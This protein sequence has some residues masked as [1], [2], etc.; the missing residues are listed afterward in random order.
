M[1]G[2]LLK[3]S[4][5]LN[6]KK[7]KI[8]KKIGEGAFGYVYHVR[9][10]TISQRNETYALKKV[11]C[12]SKEQIAEVKKE[13]EIMLLL[14]KHEA[15]HTL[16]LLAHSMSKNK[17]GR[18]EVYL[19]MPLYRS[20]LQSTIDAGP[21]YPRCSITDGLDV[22]K[23]LRHCAAG[24]LALHNI[25]YRHGDFKPANVLL[26]DS[27]DCVITDF[28]SAGPLSTAITNRTE[29]LRIQDEALRQST[30][31]YRAPELFEPGIDCII[32]GK[33]DVWAFGCTMY[34]LFYSRTPFESTK[35]GM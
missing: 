11:I 7:Y 26:T 2:S 16:M 25:G 8:I 9:S 13:I 24:L 14:H 20:S 15:P 33:A 32:D 30:A 28:G 35:E 23:V 3:P 12:Q 4:I 1:L 31:S 5:V 19:L 21:G 27:L 10:A 22:V 18:Q 17:D 34:C 6:D 29:A